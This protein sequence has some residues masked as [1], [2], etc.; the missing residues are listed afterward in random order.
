VIG[1]RELVSGRFGGRE[2]VGSGSDGG[3]A[4]KAESEGWVGG[5]GKLREGLGTAGRGPW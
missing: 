1:D 5:R 3:G 2:F 4:T